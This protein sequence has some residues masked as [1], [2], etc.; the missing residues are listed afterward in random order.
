MG[1]KISPHLVGFISRKFLFFLFAVTSS[2][3]VFSWFFVFRSTTGQPQFIDHNLL[4]NSKLFSMMENSE[5]SQ[6]LVQNENVDDKQDPPR[7]NSIGKRESTVPLKVFMYDLPPEFHFELLDWKAEGGSVW[8]DI[9]TKIPGYPGGLNL[10]HSIEYWLTLDILLS[11]FRDPNGVYSAVRV[12]N[13]SE[14]DV[15]FVPFFFFH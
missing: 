6:I 11:T 7:E 13:S 12:L 4:P 1:E 8:P 15:V 10:Q 14:A 3:F 9:R 5:D 2:F